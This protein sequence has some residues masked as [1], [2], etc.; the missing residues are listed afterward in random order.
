MSLYSAVYYDKVAEIEIMALMQMKIDLS[1]RILW[2]DF[3]W[4]GLV[5][6]TKKKFGFDVGR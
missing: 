1:Y 3:F 4:M 2:G 6:C 5:L